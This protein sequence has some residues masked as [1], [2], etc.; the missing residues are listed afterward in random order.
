MEVELLLND[1]NGQVLPIS[2]GITETRANLN[3]SRVIT[4]QHDTRELWRHHEMTTVHD[5]IK[6]SGRVLPRS[7]AVFHAYVSADKPWVARTLS[8]CIPMKQ[9]KVS[10]SSSTHEATQFVGPQ[11]LLY[12]PVHNSNLLN[13]ARWSVVNRHRQGLPPL[14]PWIYDPVHT[15]SFP[16]SILHFLLITPPDLILV[17]SIHYSD[18]QPFA[19][20]NQGIKS[21]KS[22]K[23]N[24][25][26]N[27]YRNSTR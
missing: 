10:S 22:H 21:T 15:P 24:L 27:F 25:P 17:P 12:A 11:K 20:T 3:L 2:E 9:G 6:G 14:E 18:S 5:V 23:W 1:C 19:F 16:S 4:W 26:L 7:C 13:E 8:H